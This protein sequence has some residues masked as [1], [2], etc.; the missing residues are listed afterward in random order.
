DISGGQRDASAVAIAHAE[1][2]QVVVDAVRAWAAP[3]NPEHAIAEAAAF[4]RTYGCTTITG[5]RYAGQFPE[6][7][8]R[9]HAVWYELSALDRSALYRELLP[10]VL[11]RTVSIPNDAQLLKELR[12]LERRRGFGGRGDRIDHRPNAHDDRANALAGAV[13]L[14][15]RPSLGGGEATLIGYGAGS[16]DPTGS[17]TNLVAAPRPIETPPT[18]PWRFGDVRTCPVPPRLRLTRGG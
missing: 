17:F 18:R 15:S 8:F 16:A 5:D 1:G 6:Q 11:S 9:R 2:G 3:H 14:V 7:A 4:I 13:W 10:R 12:G